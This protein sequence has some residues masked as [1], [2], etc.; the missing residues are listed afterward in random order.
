MASNNESIK[1]TILGSGGV[2]KT[3]L[4]IRYITGTFTSEY[5]PTIQD[6]FKK[7]VKLDDKTYDIVCIDTAGQEELRSITFTAIDDTKLFAIVFSLAS[8]I[9]F[10]E[11][12]EFFEG[13]KKKH[14]N[15]ARI[16]FVGNKADLIERTVTQE[17]AQEMAKRY[18]AQ[19]IE[20]SAKEGTNVDDMFTSIIRAK[21][22]PAA[23]NNSNTEAS[24]D[25]CCL[26][27]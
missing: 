12:V 25:G 24:S 23:T 3:S 10:N 27:I 18:G 26:V 16:V 6:E 9:S 17:Q 8:T 13:V 1:V 22:A 4:I 5:M 14:P 7:T 21:A 15:D 11:T 20:T 19:Y 2:G